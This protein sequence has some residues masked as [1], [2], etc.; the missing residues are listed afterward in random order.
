MRVP[1]AF[2]VFDDFD[3]IEKYWSGVLQYVFLLGFAW[4]M[5]ILVL[6]VST[7]KCVFNDY[8]QDWQRCSKRSILIYCESKNCYNFPRKK[9]LITW[10]SLIQPCDFRSKIPKTLL[11]IR[12]R[13]SHLSD[14]HVRGIRWINL[15][16]ITRGKKILG[17][18]SSKVFSYDE[19]I[20]LL[21]SK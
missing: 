10:W 9:M 15:R 16:H 1:W 20:L 19:H 12:L 21:W 5:I 18:N 8:T 7:N 4:W 13:P 2:L 6:W 11:E 3:S 17:R 14:L